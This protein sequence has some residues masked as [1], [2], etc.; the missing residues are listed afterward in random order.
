MANGDEY[1]KI[2]KQAE[3]TREDFLKDIDPKNST[4]EILENGKIIFFPVMKS[5]PPPKQARKQLARKLTKLN[6]RNRK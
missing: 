4:A 2:I 6:E 5:N 1:E 3:S